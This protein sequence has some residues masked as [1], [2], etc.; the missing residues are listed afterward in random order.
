MLL[1]QLPGYYTGMFHNLK[2]PYRVRGMHKPHLETPY[3]IT[4]GQRTC[5][6]CGK[7]GLG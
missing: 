1:V 4:V 7:E 6:R 5:V 3:V 2:I